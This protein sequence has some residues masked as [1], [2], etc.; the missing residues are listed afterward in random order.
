M[1][2]DMGADGKHMAILTKDIDWILTCFECKKKSSLKTSC[3]FCCTHSH[4]HPSL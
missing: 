4:R 3:V 1:G 2:P